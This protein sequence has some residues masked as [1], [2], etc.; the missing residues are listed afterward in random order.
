MN[1]VEEILQ[2]LK[3]V[4]KL[5]TWKE[6]ASYLGVSESVIS[7]W[8]KR[9]TDSAIEK[10]LYRCRDDISEGFLRTVYQKAVEWGF[11]YPSP[12]RDIKRPKVKMRAR[13]ERLDM[14]I[15]PAELTYIL[16]AAKKSRNIMLFPYLLFLLYTGMRPSEAACLYWDRLP[17]K[18]EK[19]AVK[20]M[21]PV[22][23]VGHL[24]SH[25]RIDG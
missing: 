1:K 13:E 8:K 3:F 11:S 9:N 10:I 20:N 23:H 7:V 6:V 22:G 15:K 19:E 2:K 24:V 5:N 14:I 21:L 18:T 12:E 4:K 16:T 17:A 25:V